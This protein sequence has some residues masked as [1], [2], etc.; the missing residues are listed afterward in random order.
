MKQVACALIVLSLIMGCTKPQA[1]QKPQTGA[2]LQGGQKPQAS[3]SARPQATSTASTASPTTASAPASPV[4]SIHR[5]VLEWFDN[6][7]ATGMIE[8]MVPAAE[9]A[10]DRFIAGGEEFVTG[11]RGF[12]DELHYRAGG[13]PFTAIWQSQKLTTNDVLVIGQFR[14]D[15]EDFNW[16]QLTPKGRREEL[17]DPMIVHFASHR[18]KE[19]K[20]FLPKTRPTPQ[21]GVYLFD[22]GGPAGE[23]LEAV[24]VNQVAT[25]A[26]IWA[27]HGEVISAATRKGKTFSTYASDWEPDGPEWDQS[28]IGTTLH[29]KYKVP[30]IEAGKI[31]TEYLATCRK[32]IAAFAATQAAQARK[33]GKR[34][35]QAAASGNQAY[36]ITNAHVHTAGSIIPSKLTHVSMCG[37]ESSFGYVAGQLR[38]G[39]VLLWFGYLRYPSDC[40]ET[41]I[42]RGAD[43]AVVTVDKGPD[44]DHHIHMLGC[45]KDYDTVI[46]LPRYPIR[47]L[48]CSAVVQTPQWYSV[49]GEAAAQMKD[50]KTGRP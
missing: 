12:C 24:C 34:V 40:I 10:A 6:A 37:R 35:A 4:E 27:F 28:V 8:K 17:G 39:D 2:N 11:N 44:D 31:G 21:E 20:S 5:A 26:L 7:I 38:A 36:I 41:A 30:A 50:R 45:W 3:T 16:S 22:T 32:Y 48:P 14:P 19:M 49:L 29:P 43:A 33:A 47:V 9:Q 1:G 13:F 18:W 46:D 15:W 23:S 25:T 42:A